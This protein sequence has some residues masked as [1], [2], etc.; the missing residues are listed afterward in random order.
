MLD[1]CD[2]GVQSLRIINYW[3]SSFSFKTL[4]LFIQKT[5]LKLQ[6]KELLQVLGLL[7]H[8]VVIFGIC[9]T[10]LLVPQKWAKPVFSKFFSKSAPLDNLMTAVKKVKNNIT[11][12]SDANIF[13]KYCN[14]PISYNFA[15]A[16]N[17]RGKYKFNVLASLRPST[18]FSIFQ[19]DVLLSISRLAYLRLA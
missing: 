13:A 10:L 11:F 5:W 1:P 17:I 19:W 7:H 8:D 18:V 14:I 4:V 9:F 12:H 3:G 16:W 2:I 15:L 6:L